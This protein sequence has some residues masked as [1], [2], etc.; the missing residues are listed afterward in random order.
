MALYIVSTPIGNLGDMTY[1]AMDVLK[2]VALIA[3]EDTR[4]T[5]KLLSHFNLHTPLVSFYEYN[6]L[7]RLD[8]LLNE[9]KAGKDLALVSDSGTPGICDPGF[10]L[11]QEAIRNNIKVIPVPGASA[12]LS[13]LVA[14]GLPIDSFVF[15]GFLPR[16][17][18]KLRKAF[19]EMAGFEKTVI[20]YE[21]PHRI[22]TTLKIMLEAIGNQ[23]IVIAREL[24]K[25]FEEILRG[26]LEALILRLETQPLKGE[27]VILFNPSFTNP[28]KIQ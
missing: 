15:T 21:S 14:A 13:A 27:M 7:K 5:R 18:G 1:R 12:F 9:L 16:K 23:Y 20:F 26:D 3:C 2:A 22:T 8:F 10:L 19:R 28:E 11:I 4:Q 24:T 25:H 6:K 17:P